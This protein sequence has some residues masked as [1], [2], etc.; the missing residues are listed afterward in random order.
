MI[1]PLQLDDDLDKVAEL[2]FDTDLH[3]FSMLFGK[4]EVAIPKL[5][6]LIAMDHNRLCHRHTLV[7]LEDD[8]IIGILIGYDPEQTDMK[9]ERRDYLNAL[10]TFDAIMIGIKYFFIEFIISTDGL[11]GLYIQNISINP[12]H[13]GKGIG[14][15]LIDHYIKLAIERKIPALWLD[16]TLSN[17]GA[18]KLYAR[19]GFKVVETTKIPLINDGAHRMKK[20]LS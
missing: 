18:R 7:Y 12:S 6:K 19:I 9:K 10:S 2:I 3:A 15:K 4:R 11:K 14:S 20:E 8:E 17:D 5:K 16:V 1:R 13:R